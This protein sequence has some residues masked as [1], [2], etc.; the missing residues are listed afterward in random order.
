MASEQLRYRLGRRSSNAAQPHRNR[1]RER[2]SGQ[3]GT[4]ALT[5]AQQGLIDY[6]TDHEVW[7]PGELMDGEN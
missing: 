3:D 7:K 1:H 5:E 4:E 6:E 2:K